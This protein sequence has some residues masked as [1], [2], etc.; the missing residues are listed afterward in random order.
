TLLR[1]KELCKSKKLPFLQAATIQQADI[2]NLSAKEIMA[3]AGVQKGELDLLAGGPPCQ[4]FSVFGKRLGENDPRGLLAYE[5]LR[6]LKEIQPKVFVFENV[7]GLLTINDGEIFKKLCAQL[8]AP[9]RGVK[10]T[11]SIYR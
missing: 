6:H 11:L 1:G 9:G 5:Y 4:A 7:Y 3:A 2:N 8:K 10:Y